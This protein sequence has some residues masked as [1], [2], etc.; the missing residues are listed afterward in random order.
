MSYK[1]VERDVKLE[2]VDESL[3][4]VI[5]KTPHSVA[6]LGRCAVRMPAYTDEELKA[7]LGDETCDQIEH[8]FAR[9]NRPSN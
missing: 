3:D 6:G 4:G 7:G 2:I 9:F 8:I 1:I 5:G